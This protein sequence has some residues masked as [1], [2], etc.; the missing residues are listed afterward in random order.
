MKN[1]GFLFTAYVLI[2]A[3]IFIYLVRLNLMQRRIRDRLESLRRRMEGN[4][5]S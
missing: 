3:G 5:R 1:F 2:W 4:P